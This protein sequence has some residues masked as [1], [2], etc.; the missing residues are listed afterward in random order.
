MKY[1]ITRF[2]YSVSGV[3]CIRTRPKSGFRYHQM[4]QT[5][6]T[7]QSKYL[8]VR[9]DGD[10]PGHV[11]ILEKGTGSPCTWSVPAEIAGLK[12]T[13]WNGADTVDV[14][15]AKFQTRGYGVMTMENGDK[16]YARYQGAGTVKEG[17]ATSEGTWSYTGGTGKLK[18]LKGKGT[19]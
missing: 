14:M 3:R 18:G 1:K 19:L 13:E 9:R 7:G 16:A 12:S 15:G 6:Q 17:V 5:G 10:K 8:A 11:L 2:D 4:R